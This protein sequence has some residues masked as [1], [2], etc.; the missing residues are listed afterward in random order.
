MKKGF[1]LL[2]V[3]LLTGCEGFLDEDIRSTHN[4][5]NYFQSE[6]DLVVFSNG[7]FGSLITW[8]WEGGGLFFN[9][10]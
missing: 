7:M 1:I 4:Y 6:D 2:I 10:Y 8:D 9:N 3:L 5:D